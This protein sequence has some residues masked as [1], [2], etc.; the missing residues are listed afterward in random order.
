M[1][2]K[3]AGDQVNAEDQVYGGANYQSALIYYLMTHLL[4]ANTYPGLV[5]PRCTAVCPQSERDEEKVKNLQAHSPSG[6]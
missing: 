3:Y 2:V 6:L 5:S 1:K 4:V